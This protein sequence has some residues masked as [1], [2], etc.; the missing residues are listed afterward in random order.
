MRETEKPTSSKKN[1]PRKSKDRSKRKTKKKRKQ[2]ESTPPERKDPVGPST[3]HVLKLSDGSSG[4]EKEDSDDLAEVKKQCSRVR[5]F[6]S[7]VQ[8][9]L[10]CNKLLVKI[11]RH[12]R[13]EHSSEP[14]VQRALAF[15]LETP[16][17]R[18]NAEK[19]WND[20]VQMGNFCHNQRVKSTG[21]GFLI[22]KYR[23]CDTKTAPCPFCR[24]EYKASEL[25]RHKKTCSGISDA[26]KEG[27]QSTSILKKGRELEMLSITENRLVR[28][29][30]SHMN[31]DEYLNIIKSDATLIKWTEFLIESMGIHQKYI[32]SQKLR[33]IARLFKT[34][35]DTSDITTVEECFFP[36]NFDHLLNCIKVQG[37]KNEEGE[38]NSPSVILKLSGYL[39]S[40]AKIVRDEA[41]KR[42]DAE[43]HV[44]V[45]NFF[46]LHKNQF[47]KV[48]SG[49]KTV[50]HKRQFNK[51]LVLPVMED[52]Q[53]VHDHINKQLAKWTQKST[54]EAYKCLVK[55]NICKIIMFNRKRSGEVERISLENFQ[56]GMQNPQVT[57]HLDV[58]NKF[59]NLEKE[60]C[61]KLTRIEIMGKRGRR[62]AI[63][64]SPEMVAGLKQMAAIQPNFVH[65][66]NK[67]LFA[68]VGTCQTP[69]RGYKCLTEVAQEAGVTDPGVF[70]STKLRKHLATMSQMLEISQSD[71]HLLANFM[72][73]SDEVH[74]KYYKLPDS[75]LDRSKVAQILIALNTGKEEYRGKSLEEIQSTNIM[76]D[77]LIAE[78]DSSDEATEL[79]ATSPKPKPRPAYSGTFFFFFVN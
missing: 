52:I 47:C 2:K 44:K 21:E 74:G 20:I 54:E 77:D 57:P 53:R 64:L 4:E 42:E 17:G 38:F 1:Q 12:L 78:D 36:K 61:K 69:V 41:I 48:S 3:Q 9:C 59:S 72:G 76:L 26:V 28:E 66:D 46:H 16:E 79:S 23:G 11:P 27:L 19:A 30:L 40:C 5:H 8:S 10:Y 25:W 56:R 58:I 39:K 15:S 51:V 29:V 65:K 35:R 43:T 60:L 18:K 34:V 71:R 13:S 45:D 6:K 62:V 24:G 33:H 70:Q 49:A 73:H 37:G 68:R 22:R 14:A 32:I 7:K 55:Y 31:P 63:L 75:L 50:L 67:F